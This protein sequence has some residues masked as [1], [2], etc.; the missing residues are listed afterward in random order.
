VVLA[1]TKQQPPDQIIG[2]C[3]LP[4]VHETADDLDV[5]RRVVAVAVY[6]VE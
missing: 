5:V 6:P 4:A 3:P 2:I 1:E